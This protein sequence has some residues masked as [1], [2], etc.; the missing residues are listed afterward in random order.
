MDNLP[1]RIFVAL[2]MCCSGDDCCSAPGQ[3]QKEIDN[4][5]DAVKNSAPRSQLE[6]HEIRDAKVVDKFPAAAQ[7]FKKYAYNALPIVM[8]GN[9]IVSYGISDREFIINSINKF[10][11]E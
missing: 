10:K 11:K 9:D 6:M 1:I 8:A 5:A 2:Q 4:L 7:L 3:T